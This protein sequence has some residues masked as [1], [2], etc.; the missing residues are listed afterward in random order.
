M[1]DA[2]RQVRRPAEHYA[3]YP[4]GTFTTIPLGVVRFM[5]LQEVG[6]NGWAVMTVLC[7]KIYRDGK[8]GRCSAE[9]MSGLSGLTK[10]QIARGMADLKK[11][12]VIVPVLRT[13]A[14]G[15]RRED[16]S[17]FGHVA[18]YRISKAAWALVQLESGEDGQ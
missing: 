18:Q 9:Q 15:Y 6:R 14:Q 16:R 4:G 17:S 10:Y 5:V 3:R 13:N 12:G 2:G 7:Q 11:R 1:Q 8:L